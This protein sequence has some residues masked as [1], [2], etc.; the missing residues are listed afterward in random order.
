[1][2]SFALLKLIIGKKGNFRSS[3]ATFY[4]LISTSE[5]GFSLGVCSDNSRA[6]CTAYM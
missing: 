6:L 5:P 4:E 2:E 1:L 3:E